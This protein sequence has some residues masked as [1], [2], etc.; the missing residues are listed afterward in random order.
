MYNISRIWEKLPTKN[1]LRQT[2]NTVVRLLPQSLAR[3]QQRVN[4]AVRTGS[5]RAPRNGI[6]P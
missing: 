3:K 5:T 6:V 4:R 1:Y 2:V